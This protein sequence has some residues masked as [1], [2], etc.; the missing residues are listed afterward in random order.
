MTRHP[1]RATP[2]P[3][4]ALFGSCGAP[5]PPRDRLGD[6][7]SRIPPMTALDAAEMV[8]ELKAA[9]LLLGYRGSEPVDTAALERLLLQVAQVKND[10]PQVAALE[11]PL[12]IVGARGAT[13]L[14]AEARV[15]PAVEIGRASWR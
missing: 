14:T 5:G 15:A 8:R 3:T 13:V 6:G 10:L 7:A 2:F 4:A 11:L 1:P 12:V 9:P